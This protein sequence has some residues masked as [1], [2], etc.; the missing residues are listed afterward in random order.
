MLMVMV[1]V[2]MGTMGTGFSDGGGGFIYFLCHCLSKSGFISQTT[3]CDYILNTLIARILSYLFAM[4]RVSVN[5]ILPI[6]IIIG[7]T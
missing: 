6:I 3:N 4:S 1:V 2:V 7:N 5:S